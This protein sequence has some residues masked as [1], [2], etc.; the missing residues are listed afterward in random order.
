MSTGTQS[1]ANYKAEEGVL[2]SG[3]SLPS[4]YDPEMLKD[5]KTKVY[6]HVVKGAVT[7]LPDG[8]EIQFR[9]GMFATQSEDVINYLDKIADK[10]GSM[11]TTSKVGE[12]AAKSE[13]AALA[14]NAK[15]PAGDAAKNLNIQ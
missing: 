9:G 10:P 8:M 13:Q 5:P 12:D 4:I 3:E 11:V 6:Y 1:T 14:E 2:R 15:A 7:H